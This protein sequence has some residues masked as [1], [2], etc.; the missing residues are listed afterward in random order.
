MNISQAAGAALTLGLILGGCGDL[1]SAELNGPSISAESAN[2]NA[3]MAE[4]IA[5]TNGLVESFVRRATSNVNP[6]LCPESSYPNRDALGKM[7]GERRFAEMETLATRQLDAYRANV[8]C[9][10][11]LRGLFIGLANTTEHSR[12]DLADWVQ[13][14]PTLA[15][16]SIYALALVNAAY[17]ARGGKW[18]R[19]TSSERMNQMNAHLASALNYLKMAISL[20]PTH[21]IPHGIF[22]R[23]V[24]L[25]GG[26]QEALAVLNKF[27]EVDANTFSLRRLTIEVCHPKWGG[28]ISIV[29]QIAEEAQLHAEANPRLRV[30]LGFSHATKADLIQRTKDPATLKKALAHLDRAVVHGDFG[31]AWSEQRMRVYRDLKDWPGVVVEASHAVGI[32]P[33]THY[34]WYMRGYALGK[35]GYHERAIS[36]LDRAIEIKPAYRWNFE[37]RGWAFEKLGNWDAAAADYVRV[38]ELAP[39]YKWGIQRYSETVIEKLRRPE[40]AIADITP[41]VTRRNANP[42]LWFS[43][44]R[45][46]QQIGAVDA[47]ASYRNY[48]ALGGDKINTTEEPY[49]IATAYLRGESS[50]GSETDLG[51]SRLPGQS[52]IDASAK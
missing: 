52:L 45:A 51:G 25:K 44:G 39:N 1:I 47:K 11:N 40:Q 21:P 10:N 15:S 6:S 26:C 48:L 8:L 19:D 22:A 28:N 9:E 29:E 41:L 43:L 34:G 32:A 5:V 17:D 38:M 7:R 33:W 18:T 50:L 31:N 2:P 14:S 46:Q 3:E 23:A 20:D 13:A 42:L 24:K 4:K 49:K 27:L 12:A 36:D 35:L 30:L 16:Q 37:H